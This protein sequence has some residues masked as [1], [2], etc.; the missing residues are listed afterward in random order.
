[1]WVIIKENAQPT[2]HFPALLKLTTL[3]MLNNR[4]V[5][6]GKRNIPFGTEFI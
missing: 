4:T 1:M 3:Q 6:T 5:G 2:T